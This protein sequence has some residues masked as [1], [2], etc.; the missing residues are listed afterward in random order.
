MLDVSS[1]PSAHAVFS[2]EFQRVLMKCAVG[3]GPVTRAGQYLCWSRTIAINL[4]VDVLIIFLPPSPGKIWM[5]QH[6][7]PLPSNAVLAVGCTL[8]D[9]AII[10][11]SGVRLRPDMYFCR[12]RATSPGVASLASSRFLRILDEHVY[13]GEAASELHIWSLEYPM[14]LVSMNLILSLI[15][16]VH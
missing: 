4:R 9:R 10:L 6:F 2:E 5:P 7:P 15:A 12:R 11:S 16:H 3:L 1:A 13:D 8:P 14:D